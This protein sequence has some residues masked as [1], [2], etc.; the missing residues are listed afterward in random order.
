MHNQFSPTAFAA[1]VAATLLLGCTDTLTS[2]DSSVDNS[3]ITSQFN[4]TRFDWGEIGIATGSCKPGDQCEC[5][6]NPT[7]PQCDCDEWDPACNPEPECSGVVHYPHKSTHVPGNVNVVGATI[8]NMSVSSIRVTLRLY[9]W[10]SLSSSWVLIAAS[11]KMES[12]S[13]SAITNAA[14]TCITGFYRATST[15]SYVATSGGSTIP[16]PPQQSP[17]V[18]VNC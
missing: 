3:Q 17:D 2:P 18:Q 5:D 4:S 15:H 7:L 11:D 6:L 16:L 14:D 10:E 8:C 12:N 9:R 1:M 13:G